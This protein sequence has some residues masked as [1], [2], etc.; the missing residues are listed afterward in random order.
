MDKRFLHNNEKFPE[1]ERKKLIISIVLGVFYS[2]IFYSFLYL[3]REILRFFSTIDIEYDIYVLSDQEVNFYNLFF[4]YLSLIFTQSFCFSYW[5]G[6]TRRPFKK[7][8]IQKSAIVNDQQFLNISFLLWFSRLAIVYALYIGI[9]STGYAFSFYPKYSYLF[10]ICL[11][12]L[13][14]QTWVTI[15]RLY[16]RKALKWMLIS[17]SII[18]VLAFSYSR[19]NLIDYQSINEMVLERNIAYKYKMELVE[20]NTWEKC[21]PSHIKNI[22]LVNQLSDSGKLQQ[23]IHFLN[24]NE[25]SFNDLEMNIIHMSIEEPLHLYSLPYCYRLYVDKS[26]KMSF[27]NRLKKIMT[28]VGLPYVLCPII[29]KNRE[30][31]QRYYP[32]S[33]FVWWLQNQELYKNIDLKQFELL[34]VSYVNDSIQMNNIVYATNDFYSEIKQQIEKHDNYLVAFSVDE[35]MAFADYIFVLDEFRRAVKS[36]RD[37]YAIKNYSKTCEMLESDEFEIVRNKIPSRLM[38]IDTCW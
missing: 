31:D 7:V 32:H 22:H 10:I 11:I 2:F 35:D 26:I 12:V 8:N 5:F 1:I 33:Y 18:S 14:L 25:L 20:V 16:R 29:P 34:S 36:I 13:F 38:E 17:A 15:R 27:V 3:S 4:A 19:I 24:A 9:E 21:P 30:H 23:P 6:K 28:N 37:K